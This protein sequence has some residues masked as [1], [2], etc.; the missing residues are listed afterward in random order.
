M[1]LFPLTRPFRH[2]AK[3]HGSTWSPSSPAGLIYLSDPGVDSYRDTVGGTPCTDG[4]AC[5]ATRDQIGGHTMTP[6]GGGDQPTYRA[7]GLNG[8]PGLQFDQTSSSQYLGNTSFNITGLSGATGI[9]AAKY[10]NTTG[11]QVLF[12]FQA[13]SG[14]AS[15]FLVYI[16]SGNFQ[17][18]VTNVGGVNTAASTHPADTS[19]H[20]L[21]WRYDGS[22]GFLSSKIDHAD[23]LVNW[24]CPTGN[25][26]DS[27]NG[28]ALGYYPMLTYYASAIV[29]QQAMYG[30]AL[31]DADWQKTHN[32]W[33]AK[34]GI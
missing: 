21:S 9:V 29:G 8:S 4:T 14:D 31:S 20:I 2:P 33:L 32:A 15:A 17:F 7:T 25:I 23:D 30:A 19:P 22:T 27:V 28:L 6:V 11:L 1:S 16:N 3:S 18:A 26:H 13:I 24:P 12:G 10:T 34:Y 5:A